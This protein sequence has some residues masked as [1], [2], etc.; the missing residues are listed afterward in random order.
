MTRHQLERAPSHPT[1]PRVMGF[2]TLIWTW[3]VNRGIRVNVDARGRLL[4]RAPR[5]T[6]AA[7]FRAIAAHEGALRARLADRPKPVE[8]T[9]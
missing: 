4:V 2:K 6:P 1:R 7:V 5:G 9:P 3:F 8:A